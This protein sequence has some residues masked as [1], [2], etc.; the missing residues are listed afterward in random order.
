M[1]AR[2]DISVGHGGSQ[3]TSRLQREVSPDDELV[4]PV[5]VS[6]LIRRNFEQLLGIASVNGMPPGRL[7]SVRVFVLSHYRMTM[8][9]DCG[10]KLRLGS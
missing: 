2:E 10:V 8:S 4:K 7:I 5:G 3:D 9:F 1:A 6:R